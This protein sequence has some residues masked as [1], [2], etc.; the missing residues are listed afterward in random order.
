MSLQQIR[1]LACCSIGPGILYLKQNFKA[2]IVSIIANMDFIESA[3]LITWIILSVSSLRVLAYP[4]MNWTTADIYCKEHG[5]LLTMKDEEEKTFTDL[6]DETYWVF[7]FIKYSN[8]VSW[9]GCY[10][11]SISYMQKHPFDMF[12][13]NSV[14]NCTNWCKQTVA[15]L[16]FIG[17][18]NNTCYCLSYSNIEEKYHIADKH[19]ELFDN[20]RGSTT[21]INANVYELHQHGHI[22]LYASEG[23]IQQQCVYVS[24]SPIQN[25][26]YGT[27][28]CFNNANGYICMDGSLQHINNACQPLYQSVC[29][30]NSST[31]WFNANIECRKYNGRLAKLHTQE[32]KKYMQ[33]LKK[34]WIGLFRDFQKETPYANNQHQNACLSVRKTGN[35]INFDPDD[36]SALKVPLCKNRVPSSNPTSNQV[37]IIS[38]VS[39]VVI[40]LCIFIVTFLTVRKLKTFRRGAENKTRF[41]KVSSDG[42]TTINVIN[43]VALVE[44]AFDNAEEDLMVE[45]EHYAFPENDTVSV[46]DNVYDRTDIMSARGSEI[47]IEGKDN[48]YSH[49]ANWNNTSKTDDY[50]VILLKG[51]SKTENVSNDLYSAC[52]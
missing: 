16:N 22:S 31:N 25:I 37:V 43:K 18:H 19:C 36:C 49:T 27:D 24:V 41:N 46:E 45:K 26:V 17:I 9:H 1:Q 48:I 30:K 4:S 2:K 39:A 15:S 42:N 8:F 33:P 35:K 7:G 20:T 40:F 10:N 12:K 50:D 6:K 23:T 52:K 11:I 14:Y 44:T 34:Y 21:S 3:V 5:G 38:T 13:D 29:I 51:V 32:I 28:S 47:N